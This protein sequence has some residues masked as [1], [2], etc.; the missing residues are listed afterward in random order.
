MSL[1]K[2]EIHS[3][4]GYDRVIKNDLRYPYTYSVPEFTISIEKPD[5]KIKTYGGE[6]LIKRKQ[7]QKQGRS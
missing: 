3:I 1:F 7:R 5:D 6:R 2:S 4:E